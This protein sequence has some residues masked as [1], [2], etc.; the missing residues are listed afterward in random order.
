MTEEEEFDELQAHK[1]FAVG[2][3]N[4][5]WELMDKKD[6]T[7]DDEDEMMRLVHASRYHWGQVVA[8]GVPKTGPINLERGDWQVSRVYSLL[9]K[10]K[11]ARYYG[12]RC[13]EICTQNDIGD[14]D[15][16]FAYEAVAR[17][18]ALEGNK[19]EYE[20]NLQLAKEAGG[21]IEEEGNRKYFFSELETIPKL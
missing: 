5:T 6:R 16:A 9:N 13:L 12:E 2:C 1:K 18:Y 10:P 8:A 14:F 4:K 19:A 3:F 20:K 15:I 21:K 7:G 17:A 11:P